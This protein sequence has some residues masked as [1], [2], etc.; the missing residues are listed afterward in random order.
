MKH[1]LLSAIAALALGTAAQGATIETFGT[2]SIYGTGFYGSTAAQTFALGAYSAGSA[3]V[4]SDVLGAVDCCVADSYFVGADGGD[5]DL[6]PE[7][8][9][10]W[11]GNTDVNGANGLS[12]ISVETSQLFLAGAFIDSA[13]YSTTGI[14]APDSVYGAGDLGL[15]SYT[16]MLNQVFFLGDGLTGTGTG[17]QQLFY[18]PEWADTLLIGFVDAP[19]FEGNPYYYA[20]NSGSITATFDVIAPAVPLPAGLPLLLSAFGLAGFVA[21]RRKS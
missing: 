11:G 19:R 16:P 21:R 1:T 15:A 18:I 13:T 6:M 20:D 2:S 9:V 8:H 5:F 14:P 10:P 3:V 17:A 4:L 7:P 12:G